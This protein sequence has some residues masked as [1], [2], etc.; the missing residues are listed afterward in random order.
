MRNILPDSDPTVQTERPFRGR[1]I[2]KQFGEIIGVVLGDAVIGFCSRDSMLH[3]IG[4]DRYGSE[5]EA[6][7]AVLLSEA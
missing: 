1:L 4:R 6:I 7:D 3:H 2:V 5:Q